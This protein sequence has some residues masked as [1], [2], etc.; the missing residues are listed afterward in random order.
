M[1]HA[2]SYARLGLVVLMLSVLTACIVSGVTAAF[3][4]WFL[5]DWWYEEE[6]YTR[7]Y[8]CLVAGISFGTSYIAYSSM[9]ASMIALYV[10]LVDNPDKLRDTK[11]E[12]YESVVRGALFGLFD[13]SYQSPAS[14]HWFQWVPVA[15]TVVEGPGGDQ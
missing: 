4:D 13:R 3:Y 2:R 11:P 7:Y 1:A 9:D 8:L 6:G 14:P 5:D 12:V 10:C 15:D